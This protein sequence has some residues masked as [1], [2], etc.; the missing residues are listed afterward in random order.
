MVGRGGVRVEMAHARACG[1]ARERM[2]EHGRTLGATQGYTRVWYTR[3][4]AAR[5]PMERLARRGLWS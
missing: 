1:R 3:G 4:S 5:P 2:G